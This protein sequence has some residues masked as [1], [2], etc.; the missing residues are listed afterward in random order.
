MKE[1]LQILCD[2]IGRDFEMSA[3]D[4]IVLISIK[5]GKV[6]R[7]LVSQIPPKEDISPQVSF[8]HFSSCRL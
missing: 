4:D 3:F 7:E 1:F 8:L 6:V 2:F 5:N